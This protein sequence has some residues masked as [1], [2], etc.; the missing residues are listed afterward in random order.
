LY[1]WRRA[2]RK[3]PW[4]VAGHPLPA[5]F[6]C[7]WLLHMQNCQKNFEGE[8]PDWALAFIA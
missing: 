7:H 4:L 1:S 8:R 6:C 3:L 2:L 5:F